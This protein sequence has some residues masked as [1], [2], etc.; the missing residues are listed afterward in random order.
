EEEEEEE[1]EM[2]QS[3]RKVDI[4]IKDE[5]EK[6]D[7]FHSAHTTKDV[8]SPFHLTVPSNNIVHVCVY[9]CSNEESVICICRNSGEVLLS[10]LSSDTDSKNR[11]SSDGNS[12]SEEENETTCRFECVCADNEV[13]M[14]GSSLFTSCGI[15]I[16]IA[17]L[18]SGILHTY[19]LSFMSRSEREDQQEQ[20]RE[21]LKRKSIGSKP[22]DLPSSF[23]RFLRFAHLSAL[24]SI[25]ASIVHLPASFPASFVSFTVTTGAC[26]LACEDIVGDG[27]DVKRIKMPL[28]MKRSSK[29]P[30]LSSIRN[31]ISSNTNTH[32]HYSMQLSS[33]A[34]HS[35]HVLS[36][37]IGGLQNS[38]MVG[39]ETE[40]NRSQLSQSKHPISD[41]SQYIT[42][43]TDMTVSVCVGSDKNNVCI[44]ECGDV[45]IY[46]FKSLIYPHDSFKTTPVREGYLSQRIRSSIV[47]QEEKE[48]DMHEEKLSLFSSPSPQLTSVP[49]ISTSI[50]HQPMLQ[51]GVNTGHALTLF[52]SIPSYSIS[53]T[54]TQG[55]ALSYYEAR[56]RTISNRNL[57]LEDRLS[58]YVSRLNKMN[59][60]KTCMMK[61]AAEQS[62]TIEMLQAKVLDLQSQLTTKQNTWKVQKATLERDIKKL[63]KI[64]S[65]LRQENIHLHERVRVG[66]SAGVLRVY[67]PSVRKEKTKIS[68]KSKEVGIQ[69]EL[70]KEEEEEKKEEEEKEEEEEENEEE[71]EESGSA[72]YIDAKYLEQRGRLVPT[73]RSHGIQCS[74][75]PE[76]EASSQTPSFFLM[77]SLLPPSSHPNGSSISQDISTNPEID[78]L[79]IDG[80]SVDG[81]SLHEKHSNIRFTLSAS[82]TSLYQP[83][84]HEIGTQ[85]NHH[86][87]SQR[88]ELEVCINT[89]RTMM[90]CTEPIDYTLIHSDYSALIAVIKEI[91][92]K[93]A[94]EKSASTSGHSKSSSESPRISNPTNGIHAKAFHSGSYTVL[95]SREPQTSTLFSP[96][97]QS[98]KIATHV[99]KGS[100]KANERRESHFP[101]KM[102]VP[103]PKTLQ[104]VLPISK[105][106]S[107][108]SRTSVL[109][110]PLPLSLHPFHPSDRI[111]HT[112]GRMQDKAIGGEHFPSSHL[113]RS[114]HSVSAKS[115]AEMSDK[116]DD[117]KRYG[118]PYTR[119]TSSSRVKSRDSTTQDLGGP[120]A[121]KKQLK[122][123]ENRSNVEGNHEEWERSCET[124]SPRSSQQQTNETTDEHGIIWK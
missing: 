22:S 42:T 39:G 122:I 61:E 70:V 111:F 100:V 62:E 77:D 12:E 98:S 114:I 65:E 71:E 110:S 76:S 97:L 82:P 11:L 51:I 113:A 94:K 90:R 18:S 24:I 32:L 33:P 2:K 107:I 83:L 117:S 91:I 17:S 96:S 44:C 109:S 53:H 63:E 25:P 59:T 72:V 30:L 79:E 28:W 121:P 85:T 1:G 108:P 115:S 84:L 10:L 27:D 101:A 26:V 49:A 38:L 23:L 86:S 103:F 89:L 50:L 68:P 116:T 55:S 21:R 102:F 78:T 3:G 87:H 13:V 15:P 31:P 66:A 5:N 43:S 48:S 54:V 37:N 8:S 14:S 16:F 119:L 75:H 47:K 34:V 88:N 29:A 60:D 56:N 36:P 73:L 57:F 7:E 69:V 112:S 106:P 67:S 45:I 120:D 40:S 6:D 19:E 95:G 104:N 99:S 20:E 92:G 81:S 64:S 58:Y 4:V 9:Q 124:P 41:P 74:I 35:T 52:H 80:W 118:A 93:L 46:D 123:V 105:V